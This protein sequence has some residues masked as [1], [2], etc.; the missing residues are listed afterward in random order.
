MEQKA[1]AGPSAQSERCGSGSPGRVT[2]ESNEE[3]KEEVAQGSTYASV[4]SQNSA[5][6]SVRSREM[7]LKMKLPELKNEAKQRGVKHS[8]L[9]KE[10]LLARLLELYDQELA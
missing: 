4:G 2:K 3:S 8:S 9:R 10:E 1:A 5:A 7:L 6:A